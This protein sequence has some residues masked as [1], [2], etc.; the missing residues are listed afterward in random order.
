MAV[1]SDP[2]RSEPLARSGCEFCDRIATSQEVSLVADRDFLTWASVGALVEGH[3]LVLPRAHALSAARLDDDDLS[4][5]VRY[6]DQVSEQL[7]RHY[8]PICV[9]EHGPNEPG[10][11]VGCSID[12]VHLHLVPWS[13]SLVDL[14]RAHHPDLLWRDFARDD[15]R[16]GLRPAP[17]ES[18]LLVQDADG[19]G[20]IGVGATI[21][22]QALRRIIAAELGRAEEWDWKS[23]P[24]AR[25]QT[26]T[27]MTL[28][29]MTHPSETSGRGAGANSPR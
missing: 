28:A 11:A 18:Y 29:Q 16:D 15:L 26:R 19:R 23:Y 6:T 27:V 22:S 12:H 21:P 20:A 13:S 2:T 25:N 14:A 17:D 9:F 4:E 7:R 1:L 5:L 8:G 10:T 24:Q 3:V